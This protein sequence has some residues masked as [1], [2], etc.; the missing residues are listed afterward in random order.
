MAGKREAVRED[1]TRRLLEAATRRVERHGLAGLRARDITADADC[2]LGTIYKCYRD[3]DD[4]VIHVNSAT[5][6]RLGAALERVAQSPQEPS[7]RLVALAMAYLNF[8]LT[9]QNA[10]AAL[11]QHKLPEGL[12][13]PQWHLDEHEALIAFIVAPLS[14]IDPDLSARALNRR[15]RTLFAAVHGIVSVSLNDW[16]VAVERKALGSEIE[17]IVL[18]LAAGLDGGRQSERR[19]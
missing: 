9:N 10:W 8:A 1:L 13:P 17:T 2:G 12:T 6:K 11:F 16:F 14:E 7:R 4:L 18:A 19:R 5:L 3:L 15:A